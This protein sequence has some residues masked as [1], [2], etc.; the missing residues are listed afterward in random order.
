MPATTMT[1][2]DAR[3]PQEQKDLWEY[4]ASLAGCRSLTEFVV[5]AAEKEAAKVIEKRQMTLISSK[6][7]QQVFFDA[8]M[9]PPKPNTN[10]KKALSRYKKFVAK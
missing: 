8:L 5:S 9:H 1:R 10:L 7:D 3:I 4:A 2:F 6:K